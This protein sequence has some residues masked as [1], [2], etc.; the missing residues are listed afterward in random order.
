MFDLN[1]INDVFSFLVS[2][3]GETACKVQDGPGWK[4]VSGRELYGRVRKLAEVMQGWGIQR[5][6]RVAIISENRWEWAVVDFATL[7][8]GAVDVPLYQT[9]TPEQIAYMLNNSEARVIFLSSKEQYKKLVA[10]GE[11]ATLERVVMFDEGEFPNTES[12]HALLEG[13]QGLEAPDEA[14]DAMAASVKPEDLASIIYTSGT[15]GDPK[16]VM[17]THGN[18]ASNLR[19]STDDLDIRKG[20]VTISFLPLCHVTARHLDYAMYGNGGVVAYLPKLADLQGAMQAVKPEVFLAVPRVYEKLRGAVEFKAQG[21]RK[22]VLNWALGVGAKHRDEIAKGFQPT[23]PL[24]K[25]ANKLVYSKVHAAFGGNARVFV[26]GGAPLGLDT[27]NWFLDV[28]VRIFEGYGM[29]ETSPV[30]AR[31]TFAGH[32]PGTV[33]TIVPN[34]ETRIASDGELEVRGPSVFKGYWRNE[35]ATA[36]EFTPDGWFKTGDIGKIEDGFLSITDRKKELLKTS[37]GKFIAPQPIENKLKANS[38]VGQAAV[39]G[40]MRKYAS[41]LI[42]PNY[43]MLDAW[44]KQ[45]G[46]D[47]KDRAQLVKDSR[48]HGMYK[49]I[50]AKVNETLAPYE[51]LKKL[52]VV[53]EEWSIETDELTPS[54]KLKRRVILEK[55]KQQIEAMYGE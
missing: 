38:I 31:N 33:G 44:A 45:Q 17:L 34:M 46:I 41:V 22:T 32:R 39:I 25:L 3:G 8:M 42:S 49:Q 16:G 26:A 9:L 21:F 53:P 14:F 28:G 18:M 47:T 10:A 27:T 54:M 11:I 30:I 19:H 40:D 1:T 50:V 52:T 12:F 37:G 6:D 48:V 29:T 24:W 15:T 20:D 35:E 23:S 7:A 51:T 4:D 55:Y 36:K 43:Q 13:A 5:G 2:R